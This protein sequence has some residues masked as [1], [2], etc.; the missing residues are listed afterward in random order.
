MLVKSE[1]TVSPIPFSQVAWE[2]IK[3]RDI[4]VFF[5]FAHAVFEYKQVMPF[6]C[7]VFS[8]FGSFLKTT[9]LEEF[10]ISLV[11][12]LPKLVWLL[13]RVEVVLDLATQWAPE[14]Q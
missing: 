6:L 8:I 7:D 1:F 12:Y 3:Y 10:V 11:S 14:F 13:I 9:C 2:A 4:S 5:L